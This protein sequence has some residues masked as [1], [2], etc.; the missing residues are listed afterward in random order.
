MRANWYRSA[1]ELDIELRRRISRTRSG[2][3]ALKR[4]DAPTMV[5]YQVPSKTFETNYC[6]QSAFHP[7]CEDRFNVCK[8]T[9]T[10]EQLQV[11]QSL[12]GKSAGRGLFAAVDIPMQSCLLIPDGSKSFQVLPSTCSVIDDLLETSIY[13]NSAIAG[14]QRDLSALF[15]FITGYGYV[16]SLLGTQHWSIDSNVLVFMNHG[17]NK[18]YN[19]A[20]GWGSC[21][22]EVSVNPTCIP[23]QYDNDAE[24]YSPVIE[25]HL[26]TYISGPFDYTLRDIK[27]EEELLANY[28]E[29]VA[30][31][32]SWKEDVLSLRRQCEGKTLGEISEYENKHG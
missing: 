32:D 11:H 27:A 22:T 30:N 24:I 17:C 4:F 26:R 23:P 9:I 20:T 25:R 6:R 21:I 14:V 18:T 3:S 2:D 29:F 19:Y 13:T 10:K 7:E 5:E 16:S 8:T 28:L 12:I 15:T 31:E 1:P